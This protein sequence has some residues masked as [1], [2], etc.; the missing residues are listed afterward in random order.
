MLLYVLTSNKENGENRQWAESVTRAV[1]V[2]KVKLDGQI[3]IRSACEFI[4]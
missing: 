3:K 1:S 4:N 2:T